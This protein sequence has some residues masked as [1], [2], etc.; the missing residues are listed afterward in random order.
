LRR[1]ARA[2]T[3]A[4]GWYGRTLRRFAA[5]SVRFLLTRRCSRL[6]FPFREGH[7]ALLR[8]GAWV[9]QPRSGFGDG[10]V[11]LVHVAVRTAPGRG[12]WLDECLASLANQTWPRLDVTVCETGDATLAARVA[13]WRGVA[14][15]ALRHAT[16]PDGE[17]VVS[18]AAG[19][20]GLRLDDADLLFA[21]H[22]ETLAAELAVRPGCMV[23]RSRAWRCAAA[24]TADGRPDGELAHEPG[25]VGD[26]G[27]LYRLPADSA[28][29]AGARGAGEMLTIG[30][31][32]IL[33][34]EVH[35]GREMA[36]VCARPRA[37]SR[38]A[39]PDE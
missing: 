28:R 21:D 24:T 3:G 38:S 27:A 36:G 10:A 26:R 22:I 34:R 7:Y 16:V 20:L 9:A 32:T 18:G 37:G 8:D 25:A 14:P 2:L 4:A 13:Q 35:F 31:T 1:E 11:P 17:A 29:D 5:M 23:A 33:Q 30:K 39:A 12:A 15:W 6:P 19:E